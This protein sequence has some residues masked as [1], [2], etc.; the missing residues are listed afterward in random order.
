MVLACSSPGPSQAVL[1]L[2]GSLFV[3]S[4]FSESGGV[5]GGLE[6]IW[7]EVTKIWTKAWP[8][9]ESGEIKELM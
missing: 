7:Q 3:M 6:A 2:S 9:L 5:A 8:L 1:P 4:M